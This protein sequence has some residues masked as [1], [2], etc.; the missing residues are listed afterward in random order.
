MNKIVILSL[1]LVLVLT[2]CIGKR[3][4]ALGILTDSNSAVIQ[5][6]KGAFSLQLPKDYSFREELV[7]ETARF[8]SVIDA[9]ENP[10]M[11][12]E[13]SARTIQ[14]AIVALS[15][16]EGQEI[17]ATEDFEINGLSAKKLEVSPPNNNP[18]AIIIFIQE[19]E[20]LYLFTAPPEN[21]W[22]FFE[23][24]VQSFTLI[25]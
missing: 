2:G 3:D 20:V 9:E 25:Q 6:E 11:Y 13:E 17:I 16:I 14:Q 1:S 5:E 23:S 22:S 4:T 21:P 15:Q 7:N 24:V 19:D 18:N 12:I 8:I 10:S